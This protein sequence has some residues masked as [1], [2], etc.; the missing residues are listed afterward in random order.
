M[1]E[2]KLGV[3]QGN[4]LGL[5]PQT[6]GLSVPAAWFEYTQSGVCLGFPGWLGHLGMSRASEW[7]FFTRFGGPDGIFG[8]SSQRNTIQTD[9]DM[10]ALAFGVKPLGLG[11]YESVLFSFT[12]WGPCFVS[13][14]F[15]LGPYSQ[16]WCLRKRVK[17][18]H[19]GD[20]FLHL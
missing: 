13:P 8:S 18:R 7:Q 6:W 15:P 10:I 16:C 9:T 1:Q 3:R 2:K 4:P 14:S 11:L 17:V 12:F 19:R 5:R 20:E